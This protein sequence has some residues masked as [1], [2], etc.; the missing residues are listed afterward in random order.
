MKIELSY[1][2]LI[3]DHV[4]SFYLSIQLATLHKYEN[5]PSSRFCNNFSGNF[6]PQLFTIVREYRHRGSP[7]RVQG[8]YCR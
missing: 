2:T 5:C 1:G 7:F 6:L 8:Q 3:R 4:L